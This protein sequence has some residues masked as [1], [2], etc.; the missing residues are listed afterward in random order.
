VITSRPDRARRAV[1][2]GLGVVAP[3]GIGTEAWWQATLRGDNGIRPIE[4]FDTSRYRI[5]YAGQVYGFDPDAFIDKRLQI[6]TDR[7]TWMGLAA[8]Q[9]ALDDAAFELTSHEPEA[10][11][12]IT[13]SSSG[14]N[15]FSQDEI[16]R[17]WS[18]GPRAVGPYMSIAWFYAATT[19]QISIHHGCKGPS[20]ALAAEGAGGLTALGHSRRTIWRGVDAVISGGA[21]ASVGNPMALTCQHSN[22]ALDGATGA[23]AYRPFDRR[24]AGAVP[25][26][27]AAILLVESL[28]EARERG[29][30]QVFAEILGYAATS[31]GV[32]P[33][34]AA[35]S[36]RGLARAITRALE[37]ARVAPGQIDAV[38]ADGAGT[39][40]GDELEVEA[41]TA[42]LGKHARRVPITVPKSTVGRLYAAAGALDAAAAML[43]LRDGRLPP[44]INADQPAFAG[45]DLVHE[46]READLRTVL[47]VARGHGG[48]N[49]ALVLSGPQ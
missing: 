8:T 48:F 16:E 47:V 34:R 7:W 31:D 3:T 20:S 13:A 40:V 28:R 21:E 1:V 33:H 15:E 11:S 41:L 6:E 2:T 38:F 49:A 35:T 29:A 44:T 4:R 46:A 14:G 5:R 25:G 43:A 42:A 24:A 12:V 45:L 18:R 17:L 23:D 36:S 22:P 9:M 10:I 32:A 30:P 39:P 27:G 37:D 19:G 26:E